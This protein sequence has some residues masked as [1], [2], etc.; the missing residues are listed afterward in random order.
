MEEEKES[1]PYG[2]RT[3][4]S[5]LLHLYVVLVIMLGSLKTDLLNVPVKMVLCLEEFREATCSSGG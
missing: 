1:W 2:R 5:R 4:L 3:A